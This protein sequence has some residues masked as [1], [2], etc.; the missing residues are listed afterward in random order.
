MNLIKS[1]ISTN[2]N[3]IQLIKKCSDNFFLKPNSIHTNE[4]KK[5]FIYFYRKKIKGNK[6]VINF[7]KKGKIII[8]YMPMGKPTSLGLFAYHEHNVFLYYLKNYG[9]YKRA[10]DIGGNIGLHS[11]VLSKMGYD[12]DVYEPDPAHFKILKKNIKINNCK[13]VNIF[14]KAVFDKNKKIKFT[15]VID[16]TAANHIS[17][18]KENLHGKTKEFTVQ[19]VDIKEIVLK[20]DL[21]KLDAEGSEGTIVQRLNKREL[22]G[23]D[24]ICEI[25]G[26]KSAKKI[27]HH[28]KKSKINIFSHKI[29][30]KKVRKIKDLP[31]H[32]TEGL[33]FITNKNF[34]KI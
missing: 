16:N 15:R 14:K 6:I 10:I 29:G 8:P 34:F 7:D 22:L 25:S 24:I 1:E 18:F 13:T 28:C 26:L 33:V 30:W 19:A 12:V 4:I 23:V 9:N 5:K 31:I 11:I 17:G 21:I 2:T 27:F 20:H 3:F 32:H